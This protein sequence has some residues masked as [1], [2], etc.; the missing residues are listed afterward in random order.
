MS[1]ARR[2]RSWGFMLKQWLFYLKYYTHHLSVR[3]IA[4]ALLALGSSL[5]AVI[6]AP[7]VPDEFSDLVGGKAVDSILGIMASSMLLV[8]TFTLSTIVSAHSV[9]TQVATPRA[10][11]QIIED[12]Q[13]HSVISIFLGAFIYSVVSLIAL[14]TGYYGSKGRV[15]L[16]GMTVM[17][18]LAVIGVIIYWVEELK[19]MGSVHEIM[20]RIEVATTMALKERLGKPTFDCSPL[21]KLDE[22]LP[23]VFSESIGYIRNIDIDGLGKIAEKENLKFQ[24]PNEVGDFVHLSSALVHVFP[25]DGIKEDVK[26]KIRACFAIGRNRTFEADPRWGLVVLSGIAIKALSPSL[27]DPGTAIDVVSTMVRILSCQDAHEGF[28]RAG[29]KYPRLFFPQL[30]KETLFHEA[31]HYLRIEAKSHPQ[32]S[33]M[34]EDSVR[35]LKK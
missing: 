7:F 24:V 9:A 18:L 16:L 1:P 32:V 31:F 28:S 8:L 13:S 12:S 19:K 30:K 3:A 29:L 5:A 25:G 34:I 6:F 4:F 11:S 21:D 17:V 22:N 2:L 15:I 35:L 27:N 33:L 26:A 23:K 20:R 14:S 10:T